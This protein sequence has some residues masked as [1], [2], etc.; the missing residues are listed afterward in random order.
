[1]GSFENG[2]NSKNFTITYTNKEIYDMIQELDKSIN[3]MC[4]EVKNELKTINKVKSKMGE[5][6]ERVEEL[7]KDRD[8]I[9]FEGSGKNLVGDAIIKWGG[10]IISLLML[11]QA[12][13]NARGG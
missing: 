1:M 2:R 8:K 3:S 7:E 12:F 10:W 9:L 13:I 11:Y 6:L 5:L 4:N